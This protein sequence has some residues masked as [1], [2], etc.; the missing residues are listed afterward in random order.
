MLFSSPTRNGFERR[1]SDDSGLQRRCVRFDVLCVSLIAMWLGVGPSIARAGSETTNAPALALTRSPSDKALSNAKHSLKKPEAVDAAISI[2]ERPLWSVGS[3]PGETRRFSDPNGRLEEKL[4][5]DLG[6]GRLDGFSPLDAA[7]IASGVEDTIHLNIYQRKASSLVEALRQ[8]GK[9]SSN[10]PQQRAQAIFEFMHERVLRGGYDLA[11]TDLRRVFDD[12]RYN[13]VSATVLFNHLATEFDLR[14][15]G[16]EMP[17][18][19]MS[20]VFLA[21]GT[22]DVENTCPQWFQLN[23]DPKPWAPAGNVAP[24]DRSKAHAVSPIQLA[25]M[26]YYNRGV[27]FL[28]EKRFAEAAA[29]NA[30]ALRLDP[31][32]ATARGNLLATVN[33]WAIDLGNGGRFTEAVD[34]LRQGLTM[35]AH[36]E[37]FSQNYVHVHRQWVDHLCGEGRFGDAVTVLTQA[38]K[39]MP[40]RDYF[41]KVE[42]EIRQRWSKAVA[43]SPNH[44]K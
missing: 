35:D 36:F 9:L 30:K 28:S 31:K 6:D 18:H 20:R 29:V 37:A 16:L 21:D 23:G 22:L 38:A 32:N 14:C 4:F 41:R 12:G 15:C 24:I 3:F 5:A 19:A 34:L 40:D 43:A 2:R 25:A 42:S 8:S 7:L 39:E 33:N 27:D 11:Y 13:C 1:S 10:A 17:S 26:I 44:S